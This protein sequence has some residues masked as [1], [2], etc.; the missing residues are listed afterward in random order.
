MKQ[1]K[2]STKILLANCF[3]ELLQTIPFE[4][5]TIKT[6]TDKANVIRPTFYKHFQDKYEVIE[7]IF[8]KEIADKVD[9]YLDNNMNREA[10]YLLFRSLE[11]ERSFYKKTFLITGPNSFEVL[12][13]NYIYTTYYKL[14]KKYSLKY[15]ENIHHLTYETLAQYYTFGL[16]NTIK[17]WLTTSNTT[18]AEEICDCYNYITQN[19]I[20]DLLGKQ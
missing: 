10:I 20:L 1:K 4:K 9:V 16:V 3:K 19:S 12:L 13:N 14:I 11:K 6:I 15:N 2:E 7:W 17:Q 5:I 8:F 18:T